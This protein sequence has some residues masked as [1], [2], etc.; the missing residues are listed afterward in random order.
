MTTQIERPKWILYRHTRDFQLLCEIAH[1]LKSYSQTGISKQEKE[2]LN[3]RLR[4][5]GLYNERNS[6]LRLMPSA[7]K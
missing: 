5:L 1:I 3:L 2:R 6:E 4:E 7:T